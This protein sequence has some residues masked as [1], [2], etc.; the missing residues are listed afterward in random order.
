LKRWLWYFCGRY[1]GGPVVDT[2]GDT[3]D[4]EDRVKLPWAEANA[5]CVA[6]GGRLPGATELYRNNF[7]NGAG[8]LGKNSNFLWTALPSTAD[9]QRLVVRL[10]D[11]AVE[12]HDFTQ[13]HAFRCIWPAVDTGAGFGVGAC[14]GGI[15]PTQCFTFGGGLWNLDPADRVSLDLVSSMA[16]C[17]LYGASVADLED[18][19]T[20]IQAGLPGG[21]NL[22]VRTADQV[23]WG[24]NN[25]T[26]AVLRWVGAGTP[27]WA[28]VKD[29]T[30]QLK[31]FGE[32]VNF[33]CVGLKDRSVATAPACAGDCVALTSRSPLVVEGVERAGA[34]PA[35]AQETCFAAG[36]VLP[37]FREWTEALQQYLPGG[38]GQWLWT[39]D[40]LVRPGATRDF[41]LVR[42]DGVSSPSW[43]PRWDVNVAAGQAPDQRPFRCA[44]KARRAGWP[45][46]AAGKVLVEGAGG[47]ECVP[48]VVGSSNGAAISEAVDKW[49]NAWDADP[50]G[51]ASYADAGLVCGGMLG[52]LPSASELFRV[53]SNGDWALG[54]AFDTD[55]L[56]TSTPSMKKD[57]RVA[58]RLSDGETSEFPVAE[59]HTFRC[60][61]PSLR[62]AVFHA[63]NCYG[64]PGAEC[65]DAGKG[66]FADKLDRP[67]LD[68]AAAAWDCAQSHAS[69]PT[70]A[71]MARLI[72]GKLS[73]GTEAWLWLNEPK[74]QSDD[75]T[76]GYG[77]VK[78]Q[79][80]GLPTWSWSTTSAAY[81][82][83]TTKRAFRCVYD[84][85]IK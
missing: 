74:A 19:S 34:E 47:L 63:A 80:V 61:W 27:D 70:S 38:I 28:F 32:R 10:D 54:D 81:T 52:R 59:A 72:H 11:G 82:P 73:G 46:C 75:G 66:T 20:A 36:G 67:L 69:L 45:A 78:W 5:L 42:W 3:W 41:L 23:I 29:T 49:R 48:G 57:F 15:Q 4:R 44:Y 60:V 35:A 62:S 1:Q 8:S 33:R 43:Y 84:S 39:L 18:L 65:F 14:Y 37:G 71:Q 83:A 51:A 56:W 24:W 50:R 25:P 68:P 31:G 17:R 55:W 9:N 53:R 6:K 22:W 21:T 64:P 26:S 2:L 12:S 58:V 77:L 76:V 40:G 85:M 30:G 16:E 79:G 13:A 7:T